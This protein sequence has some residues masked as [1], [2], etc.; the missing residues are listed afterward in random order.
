MLR[1]VAVAVGQQ[2]VHQH[3]TDQ[4]DLAVA[5]PQQSRR[6]VDGHQRAGAGGLY[7]EGG[8]GQ[9]E[10]VGDLGGEEVLLVVQGELEG[11][12]QP[13]RIGIAQ[14]GLEVGVLAAAGQQPD[15]L[16]GGCGDAGVRQRL[17]TGRQQVPLLRVHQARLGRADA[18]VAGVEGEQPGEL[19]AR[20]D[21]TIGGLEVADAP[22]P[23]LDHRPERGEVI[24]AGQPDGHADHGDRLVRRV[25]PIRRTR[26]G[27]LPCR[28]MPG[29]VLGGRR[30]ALGRPRGHHGGQATD[31]DVLEEVGDGQRQPLGDAAQ[32]QPHQAETARATVGKAL[33]Q[34]D[35][36]PDDLLEQ[37]GQPSLQRRHRR[38]CGGG[39][40]Q[41]RAGCGSGTATVQLAAGGA[42]QLRQRTEPIDPHVRR[43][44]LA[45]MGGQLLR[46]WRFGP[47]L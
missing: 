34:A 31:G 14:H 38:R 17:H 8:P 22:L 29:P 4:H 42:R 23:G 9:A 11:V 25:A 10:V 1:P 36:D 39:R 46:R 7:G 3:A 28:R 43:Q 47:E 45:E 15:P 18:E 35:R 5:L 24:R 26:A 30:T 44:E 20:A 16:P 33:V 13:G 40:E 21:Q 27:R 2:R 19:A 41:V 6:D 37:P 32:M 12:R